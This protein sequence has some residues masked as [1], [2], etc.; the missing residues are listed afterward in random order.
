MRT[1][2]KTRALKP[3]RSFMV[4][5]RVVR[6]SANGPTMVSPYVTDPRNMWRRQC[7]NWAN[8]CFC[9]GW[10]KK[11]RGEQQGGHSLPRPRFPFAPGWV[12]LMLVMGFALVWL[13]AAVRPR[14][15]PGPRTAI[16]VGIVA[17]IISALPD[18]LANAAWG[19]SGRYLPTMWTIE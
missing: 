17:G 10:G 2:P 19:V 12:V 3:P 11:I 9:S 15:G 8:C 13:Y 18:N 5:L 4:S 6:L 16:T 7:R 14:L 1:A